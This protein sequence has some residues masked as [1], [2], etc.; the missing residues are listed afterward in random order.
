MWQPRSAREASAWLWGLEERS[1]AL[2][3]IPFAGEL[4]GRQKPGH[5]ESMLGAASS[6]VAALV[7]K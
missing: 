6:R 2:Q 5:A 3:G 4:R 1:C 7:R